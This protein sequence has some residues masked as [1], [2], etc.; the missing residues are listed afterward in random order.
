MLKSHFYMFHLLCDIKS[1]MILYF[2]L[3]INTNSDLTVVMSTNSIWPSM[4]TAAL[5]GNP[6][7]IVFV[8]SPSLF[9][10]ICD[11]ILANLF[12]GI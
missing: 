10:K 1:V 8:L 2:I 5:L 11:G 7:C 9:L 4:L 3:Q 12:F 6:A